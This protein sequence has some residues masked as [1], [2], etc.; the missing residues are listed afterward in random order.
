MS[1]QSTRLPTAVSSREDPLR[2]CRPL[3]EALEA[4]LLLSGAAEGAGLQT[5]V[6]LGI[7]YDGVL[8]EVDTATGAAS[9]PRATGVDHPVGIAAARSGALY[10]LTASDSASISDAIYMIDP[11][12]GTAT[13]AGPT[14]LSNISEGDLD[15]DPTTGVLYGLQEAPA[16]A[17]VLFRI[18]PATGAATVIGSIGAAGDLSAMAF[19][20]G[21]QLWVLDT[22]GER[23]LKVDKA[24]A[25]VLSTVALSAALGS[26]AGMD[27]EAASGDLYVVDGGM[28]GTDALYTLSTETGQLTPIGQTGLADGL[29]GLEFAELPLSR[30]IS[31]YKWNDLDGDGQW[32]DGEP[33]M[34]G[35]TI[36]LD[37]NGNLEPDP[38]EPQAVSDHMGFYLIPDDQVECT[39]FP[40]CEI[41][42]PG[43]GPSCMV[44]LWDMVFGI[45]YDTGDLY[46]ISTE[47]AKVWKIGSTGL[48]GFTCLAFSPDKTMYG[49]RDRDSAHTERDLYTINPLTSEAT[50]VGPLGEAGEWGTALTIS[51]SGLAYAA[52]DTTEGDAELIEINLSTGE[53]TLVHELQDTPV[54]GI[55]AMEWLDET[56]SDP[57]HL[58]AL[59]SVENQ[60]VRINSSTGTWCYCQP[61]DAGSDVGMTIV[62]DPGY[63]EASDSMQV[64]Y[65]S[66]GHSL[67]WFY[68]RI[69]ERELEYQSASPQKVDNFYTPTPNI[70][71]LAWR[72]GSLGSMGAYQIVEFTSARQIIPNVNFGNR[73]DDEPPKVADVRV[74]GTG[75]EQE[76]LDYLAAEGLGEGGYSIP[77][78]SAAQ[79]DELPWVNVDQ[80]EIAFTEPVAVTQSHL[81]VYGVNVPSYAV[82]AFTYDASTNT[83]RWTL[84]EP[85]RADKLLL[86]LSDDVT[87]AASN[88]L[89]GEWTDGVSTYTSGDGSAGGEFR[90]RLNTLPGDVDG[91]GEVRSSDVIKIRRKVNNSVGEPDYSCFYD[92]DGSGEIRSSDVI[93][94]RRNTNTALPPGQ[95]VPPPTAP[96][97]APQTPYDE[98]IAAALKADRR[99]AGRDPLAPPRLDALLLA[100]IVPAPV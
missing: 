37:Y 41:V 26:G 11:T 20:D 52:R 73:R 86:V 10:A 74:R 81:A 57:H 17:R 95:P 40:M 83:A 58:V 28:E 79:L 21:G 38:G 75:W 72:D 53:A 93:K 97:A 46:R 49:I 84:T 99:R 62:R 19:D 78:G 60:V 27:F 6:A 68:P 36:Y 65:I 4:R 69:C 70:Q 30:V 100:D 23:L 91:S 8:W 54:F 90:F 43:W 56:E 31:G 67:Y 64:G 92:V 85:V 89:D 45:D 25:G 18:H 50:R 7:G 35:C 55:N 76:F 22:G 1:T 33:P 63:F 96:Q 42:P 61:F 66:K 16:G 87:D 77:V 80:I 39:R 9:N 13:L 34:A 48:D 44:L 24:T 82:R 94:L 3:F 88:A 71:G 32:D 2:P 15:V 14:G 59:S 5:V 51:E 98:L 29:V 47:T 12:T